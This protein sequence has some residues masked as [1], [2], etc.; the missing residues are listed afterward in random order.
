MLEAVACAG[1]D[2]IQ[3]VAL[4]DGEAGRVS[5]GLREAV[6]EDGILLDGGHR[7]AARE[8]A[9][10][11][12]AEAGAY[13]ENWELRIEDR[14]LGGGRVEDGVEGVPVDE[15]VLPHDLVR[16]EAVFEAPRLHLRWARKVHFA[17]SFGIGYSLT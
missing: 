17:L 3:G 11:E 16:V 9:F 1:L 5:E 4:Q 7:E 12:H 14:E 13:F 8:K 15:E 6:G 2:E 10:C